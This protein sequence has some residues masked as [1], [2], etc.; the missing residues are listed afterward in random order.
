MTLRLMSGLAL[1]AAMSCSG[2]KDQSENP[3]SG[4]GHQTVRPGIQFDPAETKRGARIGSLTVAEIIAQRAID[5]SWVGS[6]SFTGE[7]NLDGALMRHPD[8]DVHDVCFEADSVSA[9]KMPRWAR[10][11]RRAWFCFTNTEEARRILA[12]DSGQARIVVDRFRIERN[13]SDAVNSARLVS[14]GIVR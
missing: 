8:S 2:R 13:L 9:A 5:S 10:D 7:L 11:E 6:A 4:V 12:A 14:G 3:D 1:V